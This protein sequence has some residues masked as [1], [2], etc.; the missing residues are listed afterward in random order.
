MR[1]SCFN[2]QFFNSEN[3][4]NSVASENVCGMYVPGGQVKI[5]SQNKHRVVFAVMVVAKL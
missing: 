3:S 2:S 4:Y 5:V 1:G